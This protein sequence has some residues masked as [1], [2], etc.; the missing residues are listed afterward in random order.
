[1]RLMIRK[2]LFFSVFFGALSVNSQ[3]I[4]PVN[5]DYLSD[6]LYLVHPSAAGIGNC[7][8]L[9]FTYGQQWFG[10]EDGPSLQTLSYNQRFTERAAFGGILFNDRNGN[11]SKHGIIGSYA[12]HLNFGRDDALDQLSFGLSFMFLQNSID[13]SDFITD[14]PIISGGIETANYYNADFSIGYHLMDAHSYFT[15]KNILNSPRNLFSENLES[16]NLR[17]YLL[18]LGYYFGREQKFQFEPSVMGQFVEFTQEILID[19]N[20]KTYYRINEKNQAWIV[21]SYRR[22]FENNDF[23]PL[24]QITPILGFNFKRFMV[25]Y[26]YSSQLGNLVIDTRGSHQFTLGIDLFCD[27]PRSTGCPNLNTMY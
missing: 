25:S 5:F 23:E 14:D 24:Q 17:R 16:N 13:Q 11:F 18:T 8:K 4:F 2:L 22:S 27:K 26:T 1:M 12:Y 7:A 21:L 3:E 15:V 6:N 10:I 9:R 20:F 19:F